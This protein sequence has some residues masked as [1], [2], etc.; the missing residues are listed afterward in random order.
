MTRLTLL[1]ILITLSQTANSQTRTV[2]VDS[3][4]VWAGIDR[5]GDLFVVLANGDVQKYEKTGKK[6]GSHKFKSPP[7]LLDPLDGVR[8]FYYLR[9]G[10]RY[11]TMSYDFS[12]VEEKPLDPAFAISPWLVCPSLHEL[13]ILDSADFTIKKTRMNAMTISLESTLKHLPDK[14]MTDY[15]LIREY[16][17]YVFLLDHSSGVHIFNSLGRFVRTLGEKN[18]NYFNFLG[19]E[20]YHVSGRELVF[21]NLYSLDRRISPLD[22]SFQFVL[23]NDDTLY[24]VTGKEIVILP[25]KP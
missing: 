22:G 18:M 5:A 13:W 10:Q 9:D 11:G 12:T 20:M 16:Q 23:L 2:T 4:I 3:E 15:L 8:S 24:G 14:K 25:F 17:N 1:V 7:T 6:V 19:E 21:T